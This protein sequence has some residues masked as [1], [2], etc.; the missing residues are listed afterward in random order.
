MNTSL[1]HYFP[2]LWQKEELLSTIK[3]N[4]YL[5]SI[6]DNW[7]YKQQEEFVNFCTGVRGIKFLYDGFFKELLNPETTPERLNDFLS[8]LMRQKVRILKVLPNDSTRI[9][10]ESSLLVTDIVV[11]LEDGSLANVEVQKIGYNFP[12]QRSACYSSDLLLRQYK[13][14]RSEKNKNNHKF[15][16]KD[17][18]DVYTIILYEQSPLEFHKFS[19]TYL[20][21]FEQKSNTGLHLPLLQKFLFIPLDIFLNIQ[22]NKDISNKLDAWLLF[23]ASD[24]PRDVVRLIKK[25]PEFQVMYEQAYQICQNVEDVM[26]LFSEELKI[27]DRN[28]VLYMID[29]MQNHIDNQKATIIEQLTTIDNQQSTIDT[30]QMTL[31]KQKATIDTQQMTL[32]KQK[33]IIN[34]LLKQIESLKQNT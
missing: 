31:D 17:I 24:D 7:T 32:D 16:Y 3:N 11:E 25:Y 10:D 33:A 2:M 18:K 13:R 12:G 5:F 34:D 9:A 26:G 21:Y 30:Q 4:S 19:D 23:F 29:E 1:R 15:S 28:T 20:H 27:L 22:H 14:V 6:Y 8:L